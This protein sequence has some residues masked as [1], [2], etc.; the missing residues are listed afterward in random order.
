MLA[1]STIDDRIF[2]SIKR[3]IAVVSSV[4][5]ATSAGTHTFMSIDSATRLVDM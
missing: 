5:T 2:G 3:K 1:D 4:A